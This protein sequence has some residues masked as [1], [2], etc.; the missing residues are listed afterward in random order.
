M[1]KLSKVGIIVRLCIL[2]A[3]SIYSLFMYS[4][5]TAYCSLKSYQ[6]TVNNI[7]IIYP[8][9]TLGS[10][11]RMGFKPIAS[12]EAYFADNPEL[13]AFDSQTFEAGFQTRPK[14]PGVPHEVT[15]EKSD[16]RITVSVWNYTFQDK[17]FLD[18]PVFYYKFDADNALNDIVIDNHSIPPG[19]SLDDIKR[20]FSG[21]TVME[22][23]P[24]LE[25]T[26]WVKS[27]PI[28][29]KD[30]PYLHA[31][32]RPVTTAEDPLLYTYYLFVPKSNK[33]ILAMVFNKDNTLNSI[34]IGRRLQSNY[35]TPKNY[36]FGDSDLYTL[37]S[38]AFPMA[39][40]VSGIELIFGPIPI[41]YRRRMEE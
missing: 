11:I 14:Y 37:I 30:L 13:K 21:Y 7:T 6:T 31:Y 41:R 25:G 20:I 5:N 27:S 19:A 3:F 29:W 32:E 17:S 9:T 10:L 34:T 39:A 16:L 2:V 24:K 23:T 8:K 33:N 36:L 18:A 15:L 22:Y 26:Y 1:H 4:L 28:E 38:M 12:D 35:D 40:L